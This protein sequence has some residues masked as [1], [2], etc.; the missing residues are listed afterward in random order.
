MR[1]FRVVSTSKESVTRNAPPH[2]ANDANDELLGADRHRR[3]ADD[4]HSDAVSRPRRA[5]ESR[6]ARQEQVIFM[7]FELQ[8][9]KQGKL[10]LPVS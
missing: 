4:A 5:K 8:E 2:D 10:G 3:H 7:H 9:P 1:W 6:R